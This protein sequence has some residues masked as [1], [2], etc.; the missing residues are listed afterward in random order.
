M[1]WWQALLSGV[2]PVLITL[3]ITNWA[4]SKRRAQDAGE[5]QK[6]REAEQQ[7]RDEARR[8]SI[9]DH[10]RNERMTRMTALVDVVGDET[11]LA[12][13]IRLSLSL[14]E[15]LDDELWDAL[16]KTAQKD[17]DTLVKRIDSDMP[18]AVTQVSVIASQRFYLFA[19]GTAEAIVDA[20]EP[21]WRSIQKAS[22]S[23]DECAKARE[24]SQRFSDQ[25]N[26]LNRELVNMVR[27]E[28]TGD[29]D[30]FLRDPK[31]PLL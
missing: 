5:R 25:M 4:E 20:A 29:K 22:V 7:A 11:R 30:S 18:L 2:V 27:E 26:E 31:H 23:R 16:T 13:E 8:N 15:S 24:V 9:E 19:T 6:D 3:V 1:N 17:A 28:L 14:G 21:V 10:W 12:N